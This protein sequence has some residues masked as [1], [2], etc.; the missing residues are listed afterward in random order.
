[1]LDDVHSVA[2][3]AGRVVGMAED[4]ES[5][6]VGFVGC[7]RIGAG[8]PVIVLSEPGEI[9]F[10]PEPRPHHLADVALRSVVGELQPASGM[11]ESRKVKGVL[12][13]RA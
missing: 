4:D 3:R 1:M 6:F 11:E 13:A 5:C 8:I 9:G 10:V 2:D 7:D 12:A